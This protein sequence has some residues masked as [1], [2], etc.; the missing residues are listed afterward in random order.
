MEYEKA[1][2]RVYE[3]TIEDL[4][5]TTTTTHRR[6]RASQSNH[7]DTD[8]ER[9][10]NPNLEIVFSGS[11]LDHDDEQNNGDHKI[12]FF[13]P[14]L[15]RSRR[16]RRGSKKSS[17]TKTSRFN[18]FNRYSPRRSNH[19]DG[20]PS[21]NSRFSLLSTR[22]HD[23]DHDI[24]VSTESQVEL[25]DLSPPRTLSTIG[26]PSTPSSGLRRRQLSSPRH[27]HTHSQSDD[28]S[29]SDISVER[30]RS[31]DFDVSTT[32]THSVDTTAVDTRDDDSDSSS[33]ASLPVSI[34][35][36]K[37]YLIIMRL[38]FII[39]II[40]LVILAILH[41]TYVGPRISKSFNTVDQKK[42]MTCLERALS[43]RPLQDRSQFRDKVLYAEINELTGEKRLIEHDSKQISLLG[44]DEI[45]QIKVIHGE[46]EG[47]CSRVRNVDTK[48][49]VISE[50]N[51]NAGLVDYSS[52]TY[53]ET[54]HYRFSTNE[55]LLDMEDSLLNRYN[56]ALVNV[57]LTESCLSSGKDGETSMMTNFVQ[58]LSQIYGFDTVI[59]NQV[60]FGIKT[61]AGDYRN[62]VLQK[63]ETKDRWS[64]SKVLVQLYHG[65]SIQS[66]T[67]MKIIRRCIILLVSLICYVFLTST[68]ALIVR[69]LTTSGVLILVPLFG[70]F[71]LCGIQVDDR[72]LDYAHP[73]LGFARR[74]I[75]SNGA[76]SYKSFTA[77]HVCKL[78]VIYAMYEAC[79]VAWSDMY[80]RKNI[81]TQFPLM[82][83]AS[84]LVFEYF[85]LI[86]VR[87]A[88]R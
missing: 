7:N 86:Y 30:N 77:A 12:P 83:F 48:K 28:E 79:Q 67:A 85:S 60:L 69:I 1:L 15:F 33:T 5:T 9:S 76:H 55:A 80:Y 75:Q 29:M 45:L 3:K 59:M 43:T 23:N 61:P 58:T 40:H 46:C 17:H 6:R 72:V 13:M 64:Y 16:C 41:F 36:K 65:T 35:N 54:P 49:D 27:N 66:S 82:I 68:T 4:T 74:R 20:N 19:P 32:P 81:P 24:I 22:D 53:W 50:D 56:V 31:F 38:T 78:I 8:G 34:F 63:M 18:L 11:T 70:L 73:W 84:S 10:V 2:Y 39:A 87:S 14:N 52:S 44:S 37:G 42:R 47:I 25:C 21:P 26:S 51:A 57:T 62:G 88:L 71:Q